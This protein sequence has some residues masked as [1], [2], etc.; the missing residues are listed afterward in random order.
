LHQVVALPITAVAG[1]TVA[2]LAVVAGHSIGIAA[3][4]LAGIVALALY[5]I[6][7]TRSVEGLGYL[8]AGLGLGLVFTTGLAVNL[9]QSGPAP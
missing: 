4:V 8:V 9:I 3:L 7:R 5:E 6:A 2:I 1:V